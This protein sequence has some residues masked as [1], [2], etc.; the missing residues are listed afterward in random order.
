MDSLIHYR[1]ADTVAALSQLSYRVERS[2]VFTF[3]PRTPLLSVMHA[4]GRLFP[5]GDR[6]P[7]IEPVSETRLLQ[8]IEAA[9]PLATWQAARTQRVNSRF[10]Q[11]QA[12][13]LVR[14]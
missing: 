1:A 6:A 2:I 14:A 10:Y 11:S 8:A 13:E 7:S 9:Q 5:R 4:A 3:A 12:L